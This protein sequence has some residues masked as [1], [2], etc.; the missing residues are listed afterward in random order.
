MIVKAKGVYRNGKVELSEPQ[1]APPE[2][3]PVVIQYE[4]LQRKGFSA[5]FGVL[6]QHQAEAMLAAI[7][8]SC[9]RI[10]N[11]GW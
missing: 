2:G 9:E 5:H 7:E 4:I 11:D 10:D 1:K 6:D 8:E 3:T